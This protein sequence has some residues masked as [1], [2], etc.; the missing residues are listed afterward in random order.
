MAPMM[1]VIVAEWDSPMSAAMAWITRA[2]SRMSFQD[3]G[4]ASGGA[5][6]G[7][8][9]VCVGGAEGCVGGVREHQV[10]RKGSAAGR[11]GGRR[12]QHRQQL[13]APPSRALLMTRRAN[14]PLTSR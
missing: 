2:D 7:G 11:R 10:Q 14:L 3:H 4:D 13:N 9:W 12:D 6:L 8:V 5:R 1:S